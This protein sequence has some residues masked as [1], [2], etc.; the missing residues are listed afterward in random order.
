MFCFDYCDR[1]ED[2][3]RTLVISVNTF[4]DI[5]S[6]YTLYCKPNLYHIKDIGHVIVVFPNG[7]IFNCNPR[8]YPLKIVS[9]LSVL[10][11]EQIEPSTAVYEA[12]WNNHWD[13]DSLVTS[14]I[15]FDKNCGLWSAY[16]LWWYE[17]NKNMEPFQHS[18]YDLENWIKLVCS[19][20]LDK[21][22][23]LFIYY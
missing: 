11:N 16:Y 14:A 13:K 19:E 1:I 15:E 8:D 10:H 17:N 3:L 6:T 22:N 23:E 4:D 18:L 9:P 12:Y 20:Y 5:F 2:Y 21:S 7:G